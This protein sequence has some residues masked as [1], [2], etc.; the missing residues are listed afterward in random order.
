VIEDVRVG[1]VGF[2]AVN[3]V[4]VEVVDL[5]KADVQP[6]AKALNALVFF[7]AKILP[8]TRTW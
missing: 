8:G 3:L 7:P 5:A 4:G 6:V 1:V 2:A